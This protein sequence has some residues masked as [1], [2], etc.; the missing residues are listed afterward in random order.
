MAEISKISEHRKQDIFHQYSDYFNGLAQGNLANLCYLRP[1]RWVDLVV[2]AKE[3]RVPYYMATIGIE[4]MEKNAKSIAKEISRFH[5]GKKKITLLYE[6][7]PGTG[8]K[9]VPMVEALN[10]NLKSVILY[11]L[12]TD[13]LRATRENIGRL[14]KER[15]LDEVNITTIT[16]DWSSATDNAH[17]ANTLGLELGGSVFNIAGNDWDSIAASVTVDTLRSMA[18]QVD[19]NYENWLIIE[20]DIGIGSVDPKEEKKFFEYSYSSEENARFCAE[21]LELFSLLFETEGYDPNAFEYRPVFDPKTRLLSHNMVVTRPMKFRAEG[22]EFVLPR[23]FMNATINSFKPTQEQFL[24]AAREAEHECIATFHDPNNLTAL[25][26]FHRNY[27]SQENHSSNHQVS[28][29]NHESELIKKLN[30]CH[31][32]PNVA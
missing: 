7:G 10:G 8:E 19:S 1:E 3:G 29:Q 2:A 23:G 17:C 27:E 9:V 12:Q 28:R 32:I 16:E 21:P 22:Q 26:L 14:R 13:F 20:Q 5:E 4:T 24:V 31:Y 6:R 25:H 30:N 11:D 18:D 15:D